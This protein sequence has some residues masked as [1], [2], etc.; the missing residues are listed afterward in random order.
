RRNHAPTAQPGCA[1]PRQEE[2]VPSKVRV[3]LYSPDTMGIGHMRRNLLIAQALAGGPSPAVILLI[4]GAHEIN[5]FGVP[6]GA[7]CLSLPALRKGGNGHYRARHLDLPL[8][9]LIAVRARSIAAALEAFA[10]DVL[11]LD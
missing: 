10:P 2:N 9:E 11:V 4:A 1:R 8:G 7:D 5:A 3:A 6:E